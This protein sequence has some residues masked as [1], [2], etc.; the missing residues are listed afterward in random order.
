MRDF[1]FPGWHSIVDCIMATYLKDTGHELF[2]PA[3]NDDGFAA[4]RTA[5][6]EYDQYQPDVSVGSSRGGAVAMNIKS[7]NTP[8]VLL[9]PVWKR[10]GTSTTVKRQATSSILATT[11]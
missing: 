10:W 1:F 6:A 7:G 5:H 8:L 2:N 3:L 9:C 4:I 11:K